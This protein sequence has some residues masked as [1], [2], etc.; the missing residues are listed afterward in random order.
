MAGA[1]EPLNNLKNT[2]RGKSLPV[3]PEATQQKSNSHRVDEKK[4]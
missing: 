4:H 1:G 2:Q 3:I